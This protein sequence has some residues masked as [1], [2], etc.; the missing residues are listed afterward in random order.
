MTIHPFPTKRV[1]RAA[2]PPLSTA[3][4]WSS[5]M[6]SPR[7]PGR[8]PLPVDPNRRPASG[9]TAATIETPTGVQLSN[10]DPPNERTEHG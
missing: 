6:A 4:A 3:R 8:H 5:A 7:A 2:T 1:R 9:M 10:E